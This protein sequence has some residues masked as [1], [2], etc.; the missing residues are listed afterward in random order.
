MTDAYIEKTL[1]DAFLSINSFMTDNGYTGVPYITMKNGKP[2]NV[3][4]PNNPF[5]EPEDKRFFV[6][7]FLSG[8]PEAAGLGT[9]AENRWYGVLQIDIITPLGEGTK[10]AESKYEWICKLFSRGKMFGEVTVNKT[11]RATQGAVPDMPFYR[12]VVRVE[13]ESTLPKS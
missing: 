10:E 2:A 7:D 13:C 8:S 1:I 3:S 9:N 4:L 11:Y 6:L 5:S 12:F